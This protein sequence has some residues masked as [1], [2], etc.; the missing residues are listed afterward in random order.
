MDSYGI[1]WYGKWDRID[2]NLAVIRGTLGWWFNFYQCWWWFECIKWSLDFQTKSNKFWVII[3]S[4]RCCFLWIHNNYPRWMF[5]GRTVW[6]KHNRR[7]RLLHRCY[8]TTNCVN[9]YI[10]SIIGSLLSWLD[11]CSHQSKFRT[12]GCTDSHTSLICLTSVRW[13]D[14]DR[15]RIWLLCSRWWMELQTQSNKHNFNKLNE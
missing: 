6:P 5:I 2:S 15:Y 7:H 12:G 13:L 14:R 4:E 11:T 9:S 8:W 1:R 10:Y 3:R